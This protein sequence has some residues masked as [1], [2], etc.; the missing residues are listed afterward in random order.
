MF[1]RAS[2]D[3]GLLVGRMASYRWNQGKRGEMLRTRAP[4]VSLWEAVLPEEV[5]RL[6][7]E[8]ARVEALPGRRR[9]S[10][11]PSPTDPD[12]SLSAYLARAVQLSGRVPQR[13]VREQVW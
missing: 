10:H 1:L 3:R 2:R 11:P 7:D 4:E 12:V 8:L 9:G 6:P 5:L 13:P